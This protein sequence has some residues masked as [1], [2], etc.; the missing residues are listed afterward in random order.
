[1]RSLVDRQ[2]LTAILRQE[3]INADCFALD[4]G[5]P[6]ERYVL[7]SRPDGWVTYYSERGQESGLR[8]FDTED[9]ACR[10]VLDQLRRDP[11]THFRLVVGPLPADEADAAFEEWKRQSG[12]DDLR[13]EDVRIDNPVLSAGPSRRYWVRGALLVG[14]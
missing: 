9:E 2:E 7:D 11:T 10:H 4:G 6:S 3:G 12:F 8:K 1:M 13:P 5:H 14:K